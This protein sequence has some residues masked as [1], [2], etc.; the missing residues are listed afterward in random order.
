[1][2]T[3][4]DP[5]RCLT[6]IMNIWRRTLLMT[7]AAI[8]LCAGAPRTATACSCVRRGPPCQEYFQS[9]AMFVGTVEAIEIRKRPVAERLYDHKLVHM[10][11]DRIGRGLQG[12]RVDVWTGMGG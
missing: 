9:D 8:V 12:S 7:T 11:V 5:S 4:A 2:W 3:P 1:G 10:T 6:D